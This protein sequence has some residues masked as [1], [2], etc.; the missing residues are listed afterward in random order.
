MADET[1]KKFTD[2]FLIPKFGKRFW[3]NVALELK[4]YLCS[5]TASKKFW[6]K[7]SDYY[8]RFCQ[9]IGA[10]VQKL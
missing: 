2:S 1:E 10:H 5:L 7:Y 3:E 8:A 9:S 6:T 4:V